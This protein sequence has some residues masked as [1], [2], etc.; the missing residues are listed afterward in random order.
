M[1]RFSPGACGRAG[2]ERQGCVR[3]RTQAGAAFFARCASSAAGY[4]GAA[5]WRALLV[6]CASAS[7]VKRQNRA[8]ARRQERRCF[9]HV[10]T[11]LR[12]LVLHAG[13]ERAN[14]FTLH[15]ARR[16]KSCCGEELSP[17]RCCCVMLSRRCVVW[18]LAGWYMR[19]SGYVVAAGG[20]VGKPAT[21]LLVARRQVERRY[22][23][24]G[25]RRSVARR[26]GERPGCH[27]R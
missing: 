9:R 10:I 23:S 7:S 6:C 5:K 24:G 17:R 22:S 13:A 12:R 16:F 15:A 25:A 1:P 14:L 19:N 18:R 8:A 2:A 3:Y 21:S 27:Q 20:D 26:A 11:P 4:S